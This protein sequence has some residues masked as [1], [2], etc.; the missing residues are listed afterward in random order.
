MDEDEDK[1]DDEN[2]DEMS[3][4]GDEVDNLMMLDQYQDVQRCDS[5]IRKNFLAHNDSHKK[6]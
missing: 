4:E 2:D 3:A 5:L 1:D 6:G